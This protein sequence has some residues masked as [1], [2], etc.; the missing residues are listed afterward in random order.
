MF[1]TLVLFA[2]KSVIAKPK[3]ARV[4]PCTGCDSSFLVSALSDRS[5]LAQS[6][7]KISLSVLLKM[8]FLPYSTQYGFNNWYFSSSSVNRMCTLLCSCRPDS[9]CLT[10]AKISLIFT[11]HPPQL[12]TYCLLQLKLKEC[13]I[14]SSF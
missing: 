10:V 3:K 6:G 11:P 4:T 2:E 9:Q 13:F 12:C 14:E 5:N 1:S 8:T 7:N